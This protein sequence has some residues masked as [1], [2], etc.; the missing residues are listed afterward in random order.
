MTTTP[1]WAGLK[2]PSTRG[3]PA[4]GPG[5]GP[6]HRQAEATGEG[7]AFLHR[8]SHWPS[9]RRSPGTK[10]EW[11]GSAHP[12]EPW[13]GL[14]CLTRQPT[15]ES[16]GVMWGGTALGCFPQYLPSPQS[17]RKLSISQAVCPS[18]WR[19]RE[20]GQDGRTEALRSSECGQGRGERWGLIPKPGR[21]GH[22]GAG[23][24]CRWRL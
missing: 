11:V 16:L 1:R 23:G 8:S 7:A 6:G 21:S 9:A 13:P 5:W 20:A 22:R 12:E 10:P 17:S 15:L 19:G 3:P 24:E 18:G 2:P 14:R 4:A